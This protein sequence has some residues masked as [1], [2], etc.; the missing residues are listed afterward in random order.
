MDSVIEL[1]KAILSIPIP[2]NMVVLVVLFF[3]VTGVVTSM[4]KQ[5]RKYACHRRELDFKRDL[6][7]RGLSVEE[8]ERIMAAKCSTSKE[9]NV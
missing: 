5:I 6:V 4:L 8:I 3:C 7:E 1:F 2:F 9:S